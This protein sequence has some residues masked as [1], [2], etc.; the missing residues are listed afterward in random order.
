M[1][2]GKPQKVIE[3]EPAVEPFRREQ[4]SPAPQHEPVKT[5]EKVP[6]KVGA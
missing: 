2:I 5:P 4:P 1:E 6:E 3:V